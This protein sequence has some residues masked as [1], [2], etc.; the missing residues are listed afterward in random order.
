MPC[1]GDCANYGTQEI[2]QIGDIR[3]IGF[4]ADPRPRNGC[5]LW[6]AR[7]GNTGT[8][9]RFSVYGGSAGAGRIP[10]RCFGFK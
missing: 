9:A 10:A 2:C 6:P 8:F 5:I 3:S 7:Q 4:G 1:K